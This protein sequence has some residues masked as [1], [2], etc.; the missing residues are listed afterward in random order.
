[1]SLVRPAARAGLWR[2]REALAALALGGLGLWLASRSGL[3]VWLGYGALAV[4]ACLLL[5][6]MQRARFRTGSGGP[7][8]VHVDEGQIAYFGPLTGGVVAVSDLT[9][10]S[11]DPTGRPAHWVLEAGTQ[12]PLAIPLTAEGAEAL[13][14][15]F[16]RLP[17]L[18]VRHM[19]ATLRRPGAQPVVIWRKA[20]AAPRLH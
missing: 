18:P 14:D 3:I 19:L 7:G 10:L 16:A 20:S 8:V 17:G 1:M 13:F 9:A 2:W 5:V 11:L 15:A 4:A 12:P 6:G